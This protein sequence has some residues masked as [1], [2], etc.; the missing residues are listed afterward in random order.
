MSSP[1]GVFGQLERF[2]AVM[3]LNN[4][5]ETRIENDAGGKPLYVGYTAIPNGDPALSIFAITKVEYDGNGFISRV[6]LTDAGGGM[7][8]SWNARA[9]YFS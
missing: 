9:T 4:L 1:G 2:S 6:R 8:Y 3:P 7:F 5:L